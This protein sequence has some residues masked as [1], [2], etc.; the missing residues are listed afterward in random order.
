MTRTMLLG[1]ICTRVT[2]G[3]T[4]STRKAEYYDGDIPWLRTQEV[5]FG[6]IYTT[7]KTITEA[8]LKNSSAKLIPKNSVIIAMYGAT[9]GKSAINKIPV[10]TN[11]ACCN[12]IVD[13][14]KADYRYVY[15]YL[16]NQYEKLLSAATG[17]AQQNLGAK[18][19][20][21]MSIVLPELETQKK[22]ADYL[23][24]IDEKIELNRKMNETLE[25]MGQALFK[26]YFISNP[27]A[28]KW[29]IVT[30]N[31]ICTKVA[32]GGTPSTSRE[33]Y[34]GGEINWYSTKELNDNFL[35]G[36]EKTITTDG[37]A[38]SSAKLFPKD[39]V[40][41][42]IYAAPTVGRLGILSHEAAFNQA[43]CGL[44]ARPEFG[45]EFIYLYLLYS[46]TALNNLANGA[47]QQ[48]ISVGKV[49]DFK[50]MQPSTEVLGQFKNR[51]ESLFQQIQTNAEEIKTLTALRDSL[52]PR[53]ISGKTVV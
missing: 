51:I 19:I 41:M 22:I 2:S 37:L 43:A 17:A 25:Q 8:G 53:L 5:K 45:Y 26:K 21:S 39:T 20:A 29:P 40:I 7:E 38:N 48:N 4:P 52:L 13:H 46:R 16:F 24:W 31:D 32:S 35:F 28:E 47:A 12:L 30:L 6:N 42:A 11:Q 33:V 15:Y 9:A 18:Q 44:V 49:R 1:D 14:N 23:G 3:G 34:Y 50:V 10:A 27:E 36:S